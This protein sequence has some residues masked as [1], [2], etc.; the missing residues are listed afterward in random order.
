MRRN[1]LYIVLLC[2]SHV[3]F[4]QG[5]PEKWSFH[6]QA[7]SIGQTHGTFPSPYEGIN[8]LP[9]HRE[10]RVSLTATLFLAY[11]FSKMFELVVD[12]EI[13][14]GKGFGEVRGIA[15]F[16][17]GEIPRVAT[18]TPK[19]YA[20]RAFVRVTIPLGPETES[21]ESAVNQV[22]GLLPVNR[23][24]LVAGK[25]AITDFFDGNK[26]SHDP[27]T[28]FTNWSLMYNGAWDYPADTRGYTI[29]LYQELNKKNWS[30]RLAAAMEP[31][32][33][34]GPDFDARVARNR[35]DVGEFERR[36]SFMGR[37]GTIRVLGYLNHA[38]S[39]TFRRA[40]LVGGTPD[41]ESTRRN[42]TRKYGFGVN[43]EQEITRNIGVF[44]RYGWSDGKTQTWAF[45]Q[46]DRSLSG[47]ISIGG[48]LWKRPKDRVGVGAVRNQ[49]SG[50]QRSFLA[51]GGVGFIIGDGRLNYRPEATVEAY[52]SFQVHKLLSLTADFQRVAN[53]AHN[54]DRGPVS[55]Y[56][57]RVHL[58]R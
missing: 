29:G 27:R 41:L 30:F 25:F 20:A 47:G 18:A 49:L 14:G 8:S 13:A 21:V 35:G 44:G 50:D 4:A 5:D 32:E 34:N 36:Y 56:T 23:L 40:L 46:I 16:T 7:T 53:P 10:N 11:R 45:T 57:L 55:V 3:A 58:E 42:G 33:A 31:T 39:G 38:D 37:Q 24:I 1:K 17:N 12:P 28:Q 15:G 26:Y 43:L 19:L 9:P 54:Q 52:Y 6:F 48:E 22:G 2:Y 51:A